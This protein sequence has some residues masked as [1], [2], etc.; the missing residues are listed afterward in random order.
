MEICSVP[1]C[2]RLRW[3][4]E[5]SD[6][7][8]PLSLCDVHGPTVDNVPWAGSTLWTMAYDGSQDVPDYDLGGEE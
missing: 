1:N 4:V 6:S 2:G 8:T 3:F 7:P 5:N